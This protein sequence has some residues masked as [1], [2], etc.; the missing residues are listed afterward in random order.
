MAISMDFIYY[1][2]L[3]WRVAPPLELIPDVAAW[4]FCAGLAVWLIRFVIFWRPRSCIVA[5]GAWLSWLAW[6]AIFVNG[7]RALEL[8]YERGIKAL[9]ATDLFSQH[10]LALIKAWIHFFLPFLYDIW[11]SLF[12]VYKK[13]TLRQ[14]LLACIITM[15]TYAMVEAVRLFR[16]HSRFVMHLFFHASFLVGGPMVWYG[17]GRLASE[18][19][20]WCL[21]HTITTIPT[22]FSLLTISCAPPSKADATPSSPPSPASARSR[23]PALPTTNIELHR[24]WLSYWACWP[25]LAVFEAGVSGVVPRLTIPNTNTVWLQ[26]ELQR[27]LLT[28]CIWLQFWQGSRLLQY[29]MQSLLFNTSIL[30]YILGF[31]GAR[32]MQ[33]LSLVRSGVTSSGVSPMGTFRAMRWLSGLT[34]RLWIC[35]LMLACIAAIMFAVVRVFYKAFA[36]VSSI[37]T[38]MLWLCAASDSAD[39]LTR[40]A[41]DIYSKKLCFWVL[42][43]IWEALT[44]APY[45]GVL[46]RL[47]TPFA[48]SVWLLA[49]EMVMRRLFLPILGLGTKMITS[50]VSVVGFGSIGDD[51]ADKTS[52]SQGTNALDSTSTKECIENTEDKDVDNDKADEAKTKDTLPKGK[53]AITAM[54]EPGRDRSESGGLAANFPKKRNKARK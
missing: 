46:L 14:R 51:R 3:V 40:Y 31:F 45:I 7:F 43:M 49:G 13:M 47:F 29:T 27:A 38:L 28:F 19:L 6:Q 20:P 15:V 36:V 25:A 44:M 54:P 12:S 8:S 16:R 22:L 23:V 24:L 42:A 33:A 34:K 26:A 30:E 17:S 11:W 10:L 21:T 32:G 35:C 1:A 48:F 39:T 4:L 52:V 2:E 50:V 18:W 53:L 9:E 37:A 5:V 41:E